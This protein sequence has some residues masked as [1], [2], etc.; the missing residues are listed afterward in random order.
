[1]TTQIAP[2]APDLTAFTDALGDALDTACEGDVVTV[3]DASDCDPAATVYEDAPT[4]VMVKCEVHSD[5]VGALPE[6]AVG[7]TATVEL[8]DRRGIPTDCQFAV[9]GVSIIARS[10]HPTDPQVE[11]VTMEVTVAFVS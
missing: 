7:K 1:M 2:D 6:A 10:P 4:F 5:D 11:I 8:R 9:E 3:W